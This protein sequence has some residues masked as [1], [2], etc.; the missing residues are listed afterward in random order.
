MSLK[1]KEIIVSQK[2]Y[3]ETAIAKRQNEL[4]DQGLEDNTIR[5][6]SSI[7]HLKAKVRQTNR[8]LHAITS[9]EKKMEAL[10]LRKKEG[11]EGGAE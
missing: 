9:I 2:S 5:K 11:S 7:R 4:K 1:A 8:R 3:Y 10:A 6:D